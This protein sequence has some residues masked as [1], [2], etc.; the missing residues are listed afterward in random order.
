MKLA[1]TP[2][3]VQDVT[4]LLDAGADIMIAGKGQY[5]NRLVQSFSEAEL[6]EIA[7]LVHTNH[8]ELYVPVNIIVHHDD[9]AAIDTYLAFLSTIDVDGIIFG[10]L[11]V[12]QLA[13]QYHLTNKLI[14]NPET[15]NTNSFDPIFWGKQGIKGL[16]IA[17]EITLEDIALIGE[18]SPIELSMIGHGHL[19]MFQS[20][21]PLIENFLKYNKED[22]EPYI[23]NRKLRLVEEI[24]SE[25]YPVFQ[26]EHGTHIFRE[27]TME[28]FAEWQTLSNAIDVF[29][30]DGILHTSDYLLEVVQHYVS[31]RNQPTE[32]R[33]HQLKQQ[34][35][36][37]HDSG[38]L[39]KKTVYVKQ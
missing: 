5:G 8:K 10:D 22:Y 12:Y 19:N 36:E 7:T 17:K 39:Y 35:N 26:D 25:S 2:H 21:R 34:Y 27:A 15:L 14:Y 4:S 20:R 33:I 29:I 1:V 11:A 30:I 37:G 32:Q 31:L 28:S 13:A 16:T 6:T 24:R 3:S 38:F 18:T 9:L 23:N